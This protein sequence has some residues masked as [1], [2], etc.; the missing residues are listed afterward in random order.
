MFNTARQQPG[1]EQNPITPPDGALP[2]QRIL[3]HCA[4]GW[5]SPI[6][7]SQ[8]EA[9]LRPFLH[10]LVT[11]KQRWTTIDLVVEGLAVFVS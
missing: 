10:V 6:F 8:Q 5:L 2:A 9:N 7:T 3:G 11:E 4:A 1:T